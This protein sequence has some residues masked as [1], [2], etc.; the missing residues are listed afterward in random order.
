M[1]HLMK[2][3]K[4]TIFVFVALLMALPLTSSNTYGDGDANLD[5]SC[6][7]TTADI[8]M[9][10]FSAGADGTEIESSWVTGG[11][12]AGT[13][14]VTAGDWLGVGTLATGTVTLGGPI[15]TETITLNGVSYTGVNGAPTDNTEFTADS[16]DAVAAS[17]LASSINADTR[18]GTT[19]DI[20]AESTGNV[21]IIRAA[22]LGTGGNA[23]TMAEAVT[24]ARTVLD[25]AT[26]SGAEAPGITHMESI[27]TRYAITTDGS[28]STG[29]AYSAKTPFAA[30]TVLHVLTTSVD[31]GQNTRISLQVSGIGTLINLPYSGALTQTLTFTV[32]C[33]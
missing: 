26:L 7:V 20:S 14:E 18:T 21:V 2:F 17:T 4:S 12:V 28:S 13:L 15:A 31:P 25:G 9:G 16:T 27:A 33:V 23:I 29:A 5:P 3:H 24:D 1:K 22:T 32:T 19:D 10:S 11:A 8:D 30:D 6:G